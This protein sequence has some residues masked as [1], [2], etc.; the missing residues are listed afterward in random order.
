MAITVI[1]VFWPSKRPLRAPAIS[2]AGAT[3]STISR[4]T[5]VDNK[6]WFAWVM[7]SCSRD[8]SSRAARASDGTLLNGFPGGA[9][10]TQRPMNGIANNAKNNGPRNENAWSRRNVAKS[11]VSVYPGKISVYPERVPA[12]P[13]LHFLMHGAARSFGEPL[14]N[15]GNFG[16]S[17]Q[18]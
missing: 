2:A 15:P 8:K 14:K 12:R 13:L 7:R 16:E 17:V 3:S 9:I 10:T 4:S 1:L 11:R 6:G 18:Q 5:R